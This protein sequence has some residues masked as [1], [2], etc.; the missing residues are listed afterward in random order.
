MPIHRE[1]FSEFLHQRRTALGKRWKRILSDAYLS[2]ATLH[3][4]RH[5]D[6]HN[7]IAEVD[8]LRSLANALGFAS[9]ADLMSAFMAQ[10]PRAGLGAN[11]GVQQ[12][13]DG[14]S[15][16]QK[17]NSD[18]AVVTLSKALNLSPTELVR[19][20]G[21]RNIGG[22]VMVPA[23]RDL[24]TALRSNLKR[25]AR[26][27]PHFISGVAASKRVE[28]V[29]DEDFNSRRPADTLDDRAFTIPVDGDCQEP[30]WNDGDVVLFSYDTYEREGIVSGKSYYMAFSDGTTTFKRVFLDKAD[31]D[32]YVLRCWNEKKY[33][34]E[35][36]VHFSEVV[37]IAR[38]VSKQMTPQE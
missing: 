27:V 22:N 31:P 36:R 21:V 28:K 11:S 3:R 37:R 8:S 23:V 20:L 29:E 15:F 33:P 17:E 10:N 1:G 6:P 5:G 26:M 12:D 19:R 16:T 2:R 38:A 32:F 7:P 13:D 35:R 25:P 18:D 24:P 30:V 4:I 9:W 14:P 34:H